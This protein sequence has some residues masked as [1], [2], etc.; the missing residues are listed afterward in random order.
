MRTK[1]PAN[2]DPFDLFCVNLHLASPM[3]AYSHLKCPAGSVLLSA[4]SQRNIVM[5]AGEESIIFQ[6]DLDLALQSNSYQHE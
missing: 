5:H 2:R 6:S 1:M 3:K 4:L